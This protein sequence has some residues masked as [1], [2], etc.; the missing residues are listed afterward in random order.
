MKFDVSHDIFDLI[1]KII[2]LA[3]SCKQDLGPRP[4]YLHSNYMHTYFYEQE[5]FGGHY[6]KK[7]TLL[8]FP[9]DFT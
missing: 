9:L 3:E 2:S 7:S 6:K 8:A 5:S 4:K 1:S